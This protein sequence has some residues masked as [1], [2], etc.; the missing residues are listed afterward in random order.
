MLADVDLQHH[1]RQHVAPVEHDGV[2]EHDADI[3]LRAVDALVA[4]GDRAGAVGN[5]A[6]DHLENGGLAATARADD[7]DELRLPDIEIDV[8]AGFDHAVLGLI[9]L[10]D[11]L[12][13][14]VRSI[15][16]VL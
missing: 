11:V 10:A 1:V 12:Q 2:L 5:E 7:G 13:P 6:G 3:G 16:L 15:H 9:A 14:N 8:G 4:D